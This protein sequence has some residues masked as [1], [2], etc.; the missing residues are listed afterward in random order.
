V[1]ELF[2]ELFVPAE[3]VH[4]ILGVALLKVEDA[5]SE[6]LRVGGETL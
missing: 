3:V 4:L 6:G 2:V 1:I 5:G